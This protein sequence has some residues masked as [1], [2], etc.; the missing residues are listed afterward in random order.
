MDC[1]SVNW[2]HFSS[3]PRGRS[4]L[5]LIIRKF[6]AAYVLCSVII[7]IMRQQ[8]RPLLERKQRLEKRLAAL[9]KNQKEAAEANRRMYGFMAMEA[10]A[11]ELDLIL[12]LQRLCS[13]LL[14]YVYLLFSI[15]R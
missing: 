8:Q 7:N 12:L 15:C 10:V 14:T 4:S 1:F 11:S 2:L 9:E 3:V 5:V 13:S 6:E